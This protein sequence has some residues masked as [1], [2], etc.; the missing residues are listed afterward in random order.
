MVQGA[1]GNNFR[2][3]PVAEEARKLLRSG[4][5]M[6]ALA[7]QIPGTVFAVYKLKS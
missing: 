3:L 1:S 2:A 6:R 7:K 5:N 4:L